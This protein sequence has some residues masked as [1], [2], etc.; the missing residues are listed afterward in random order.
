MSGCLENLGEGNETIE[1]M[2]AKFGEVGRI[3]A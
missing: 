3:E 2:G 1:S